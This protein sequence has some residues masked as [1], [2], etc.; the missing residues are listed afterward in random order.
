MVRRIVDV[1][2]KHYKRVDFVVPDYAF[3]AGTV[4]VMSGDAIFMDYYSR[5]GPIDPQL[6]GPD[7][8]LLP[9]LG[10]LERYESL[11]EKAQ[12]QTLTGAEL[13][14]LLRCFD[15]AELYQYEQARQLSVAMV[16]EWLVVYKLKHWKTTEKRNLKV[17][18]KMR[19]DIAIMVGTELSDAARWHSHGHGISRDVLERDLKL[20]IEDFGADIDLDN[21]VR[22]YHDLL[23]DYV[24][25][26]GALGVVH[27]KCDFNP[28]L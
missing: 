6:A 3:S 21:K 16:E 24:G 25:K 15:Q 27:T 7:G 14:I 18:H 19:K 26:I 23:D 1:L 17:T 2:R 10:Y 4:L 5:L 9:A 28:F 11:L 20:R 13:Q 8:K 22:R 12:Q